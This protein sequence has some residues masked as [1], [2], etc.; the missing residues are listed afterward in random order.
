MCVY[1]L[2]LFFAGINFT[3]PYHLRLL[4]LHLFLHGGKH[5]EELVAVKQQLRFG[6]LHSKRKSS[7]GIRILSVRDVNVR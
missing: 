4:V 7:V 2:P 1:G 5:L 6:D 3:E